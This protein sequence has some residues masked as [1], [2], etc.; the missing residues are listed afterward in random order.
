MIFLNRPTGELP[1]DYATRVNDERIYFTN[2]CLPDCMSIDRHPVIDLVA[3]YRVQ[4]PCGMH[5]HAWALFPHKALTLAHCTRRNALWIAYI[6]GQKHRFVSLR[7]ERT[8]RPIRFCR[9]HSRQPHMLRIGHLTK[10]IL[11]GCV[12][13]IYSY[14]DVVSSAKS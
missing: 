7:D 5:C 1:F 8:F 3:T 10:C 4:R 14:D 2:T 13:R 12:Q 9:P 11:N 6:I